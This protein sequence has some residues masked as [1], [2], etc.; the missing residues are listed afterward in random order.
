LGTNLPYF[1]GPLTLQPGETWTLR[2]RLYVH[3]QH[4]GDANVDGRF[5]EYANPVPAALV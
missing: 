2:H 4:A 3:Q 1:D 5:D